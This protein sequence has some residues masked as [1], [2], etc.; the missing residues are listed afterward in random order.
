[1]EKEEQDKTP[2]DGV[3][4]RIDE[5]AVNRSDLSP[6]IGHG[7]G[8]L[9]ADSPCGRIHRRHPADCLQQDVVLLL[10]PGQKSKGTWVPA[11]LGVCPART[12]YRSPSLLYLLLL[13]CR[14][15]GFSDI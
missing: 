9:V 6:G 3:S 8:S 11:T 13:T 14:A 4:H 12:K 1:M 5:K 2:E 7:H 15:L 10:A